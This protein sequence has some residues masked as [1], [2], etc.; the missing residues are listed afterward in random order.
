MAPLLDHQL[1]EF[2]EWHLPRMC[3][4]RV[5][6]SVVASPDILLDAHLMMRVTKTAK[7]NVFCL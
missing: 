6:V 3:N 5:H 7:T 4:D 1:Y 2:D